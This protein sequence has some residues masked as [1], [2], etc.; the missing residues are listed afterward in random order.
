MIKALRTTNLPHLIKDISNTFEKI[1]SHRRKANPL[2]MNRYFLLL[3][4]IEIAFA[5][6][7]QGKHYKDGETFKM[8]N[9]MMRCRHY[10]GGYTTNVIA[11]LTVSGTQIALNTTYTEDG[12]QYTCQATLGGGANFGWNLDVGDN[13]DEE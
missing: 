4:F 11:C 3:L 6:D 13:V 5:C 1:E 8:K 2:M 12:R 7:F 10:D 9:F